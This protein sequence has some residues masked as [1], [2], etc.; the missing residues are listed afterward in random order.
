[1]N[2]ISNA[3]KFTEKGEIEVKVALEAE[4]ANGTLLRFSIRDTGIGISTDK[5]R[6]IFDAF[7][8]A[9]SSTTRKYGARAGLDDFR[10]A[11]RN[12]GRER[13]N[14]LLH[15]SSRARRANAAGR[16]SGRFAVG[17]RAGAGGG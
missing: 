14:I 2:L 17:W 3:I 8:P 1:M 5:Q 16:Y 13:R 11:R 12:D 9:D 7:S 15:G 4:S 6:I 10:A